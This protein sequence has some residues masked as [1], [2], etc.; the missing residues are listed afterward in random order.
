MFESGPCNGLWY[1]LE[2]SRDHKWIQCVRVLS[3]GLVLS[4][5]RYHMYYS[6]SP[7]P[8]YPNLSDQPALTSTTAGLERKWSLR[9]FPH[10]NLNSNPKQVCWTC[11]PNMSSCLSIYLYIERDID[12][13]EMWP[14]PYM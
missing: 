8:D 2:D 7:G 14:S 4:V 9:R 10:H 3:C 12:V 11:I 5:R 6:P 1:Q 13:I